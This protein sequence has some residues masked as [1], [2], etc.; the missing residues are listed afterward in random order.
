MIIRWLARRQTL[1]PGAFVSVWRLA[2]AA[3]VGSAGLWWAHRS[4]PKVQWG[5]RS[6]P[7]IRWVHQSMEE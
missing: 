2:A 5:H 6:G 4:E 3:S 7:K 1:V